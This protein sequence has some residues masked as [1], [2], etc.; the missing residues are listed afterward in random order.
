MA[1][2]S[3]VAIVAALWLGST[4][5]ADPFAQ[6]D[7]TRMIVWDI[8]LP[9]ALTAWL[10]MFRA[11]EVYALSQMNVASRQQILSFIDER[12]RLGGS[13]KSDVLRARA[14]L[15]D[16]LAVEVAAKNRLSAAEAGYREAFDAPPPAQIALPVGAVVTMGRYAHW[17]PF[18]TVRPDDSA[19]MVR[20]LVRE[21]PRS[22]I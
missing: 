7:I 10:E 4:P 14:R 17:S 18:S 11:R 6:D 21:M 22:A 20:M 15:A 12:E 3:I 9:R 13:P 19:E 1:A 5:L 16:A 2:L 8:R